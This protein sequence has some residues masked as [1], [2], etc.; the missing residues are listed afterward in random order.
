MKITFIKPCIGSKINGGYA[1]K[2]VME[3]LEFA[4]LASLTPPDINIE[5]VDDRIE[6]IPYDD[7]TDLV[8][9]NVD[10]FTA[11]RAYNISLE[12]RKRKIPV[13]LGGCH[14]T[15]IP[16]EA[17]AYADTIVVG[18]A[19]DIWGQVIKDAKDGKLK[20]TYKSDHRPSLENIRPR[21]DMFK[22]KR[23]LY[24]A[25]VE[26]GRGCNFRCNFCAVG[27]MYNYTYNHRPIKDVV[28]E[29]KGIGKKEIFF[30][31][32][33]II[34]NIETAKELF[35]AL[36]PLKINWSSQISINFLYDCSLLKLMVKSGC[37]DLFIGLESLNKK[38]L[39]LMN[40]QCNFAF[41]HY[42]SVLKGI[43]ENGI[44]VW[45]SFILGCDYDTQGSFKDTFN[46]AIK[47]KFLFANFNNLV[48]YPGTPFYG[49]LLEQKRLLYD[50]WWLDPRFKFGHAVFKPRNILPE[51]L[52]EWCYALRMKFNG[53]LSILRRGLE[54][55]ANCKNLNNFISFL[56]YNFV[57]RSEVKRKQGM[58][59]GY[60]NE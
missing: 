5:L 1:E 2:C 35:S 55:H 59:L 31:D 29:I 36:I 4:V 54:F 8:A 24:P 43:R 52:T 16:E 18:E 27:A 12:F 19:E 6:K 37:K 13:I 57:F 20:K 45:A 25:L 32:D 53:Y 40:K 44:R 28:E 42:E 51:Q 58:R 50:K 60:K 49:S 17:A 3:P 56:L 14:P 30:V 15:L 21:R 10:T 7:H 22:E 33:N 46:F 38:N 26:F 47:Q 11:K 23:Y 9:I 39:K 34:A 48:P 41:S